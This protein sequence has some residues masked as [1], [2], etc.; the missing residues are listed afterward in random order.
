MS[1]DRTTEGALLDSDE[2]LFDRGAGIHAKGSDEPRQWFE[3][4]QRELGLTLDFEVFAAR[5][6]QAAPKPAHATDL[7]LAAACSVGT[8]GAA[9]LLLRRYGSAIATALGRMKLT[10]TQRDD[11]FSK[12]L[13]VV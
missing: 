7:F 11:A 2:Q 10:P 3:A 1:T 12:A 9:E 5:V 6:E 8:P 13:E 4:A